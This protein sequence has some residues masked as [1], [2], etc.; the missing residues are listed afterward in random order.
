MVFLTKGIDLRATF[1]DPSSMDDPDQPIPVLLAFVPRTASPWACETGA[2]HL[3][4]D[5][6]AREIAPT[7]RPAARFSIFNRRCKDRFTT[8]LLVK[9][10]FSIGYSSVP[11]FPSS[12]VE[13]FT[14]DTTRIIP[15]RRWKYGRHVGATLSRLA[16]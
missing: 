12:V 14:S 7:L 8:V 6:I 9:T 11:C 5:E 2:Q 13:S 4:K 10:D 1:V 15:L 16:L 3:L